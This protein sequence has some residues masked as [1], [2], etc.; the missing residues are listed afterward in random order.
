MVT[1]P[2]RLKVVGGNAIGTELTVS[3]ELVLGRNSPGDGQLGGDAEI[4]RH[5]A[6]LTVDGNGLFAVEDLGS[7][8]GTFVN[9]LRITAPQTL[10]AGDTIEVGSTTLIVEELPHVSAADTAATPPP[11]TVTE[12]AIPRL[13]VH[14]DVDFEA[15]EARV[16]L[17]EASEPVRL[18]YDAGEWR[19]KP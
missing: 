13:S 14:F 17:D 2:A 1:S 8:N 12:E 15:R 10:G 7:T 18:V 3:D 19:V 9:G 16:R 4:S 11:P 6:R 5:H